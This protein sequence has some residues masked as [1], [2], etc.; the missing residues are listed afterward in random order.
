MISTALLGKS[1]LGYY[2]KF[3]ATK[4]ETRCLNEGGADPW[5]E[6]KNVK[7]I[8]CQKA[9]MEEDRVGQVLNKMIR[10]EMRKSYV[11]WRVAKRDQLHNQIPCC[12]SKVE[13]G[14]ENRSICLSG[15][16]F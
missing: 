5:V 7:S 13:S 4:G 3:Q 16:I 6:K 12:I 15:N 14:V 11:R 8:Y 1:E 10:A 2:S 9:C